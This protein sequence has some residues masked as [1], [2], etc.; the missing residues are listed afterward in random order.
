MCFKL[1][2]L[3]SGRGTN[4][5]ALIDASKMGEMPAQVGSSNQ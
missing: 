1:A 4:L 2:V 3:A 5:Q